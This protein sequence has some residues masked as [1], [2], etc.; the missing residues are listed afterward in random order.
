MQAY[1]NDHYSKMKE[2]IGID[3]KFGIEEEDPK[4]EEVLKNLRGNTDPTNFKRL[5]RV[6]QQVFKN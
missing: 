3:E 1:F 6:E 2:E 4:L 5:M